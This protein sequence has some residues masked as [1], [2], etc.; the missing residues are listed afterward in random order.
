MSVCLSVSVCLC[1][2]VSKR[3]HVCR[4]NNVRCMHQ[5][6]PSKVAIAFP[7]TLCQT[8]CTNMFL[9][10]DRCHR[11]GPSCR[12]QFSFIVDAATQITKMERTRA[13]C[14]TAQQCKRLAR[15]TCTAC[16]TN[17]CAAPKGEDAKGIGVRFEM[18]ISSHGV[19]FAGF[20]VL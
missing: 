9:C 11:L 1:M 19:S 4:T 10:R 8:R 17:S 2:S 5:P 6:R 16:P 7:T 14:L 20:T 3:M 18:Q 15:G 12:N 13:R